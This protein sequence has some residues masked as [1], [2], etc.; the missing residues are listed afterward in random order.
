MFPRKHF[1]MAI[2][3]PVLKDPRQPNSILRVIEAV[4]YIFLAYTYTIA[5]RQ[6]VRGL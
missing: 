2:R 3:F 6:Y 4:I 1:P 5:D